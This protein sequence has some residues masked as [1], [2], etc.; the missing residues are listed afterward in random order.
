MKE[1]T[2]AKS[3]QTSVKYLMI[4]VLACTLLSCEKDKEKYVI[5]GIASFEA[6]INA[7]TVKLVE[8]AGGSETDNPVFWV[9]ERQTFAY[10]GISNYI[11]EVMR[12]NLGNCDLF[13]DI[14]KNTISVAFVSHFMDEI[15]DANWEITRQ[16]FE[17]VLSEGS[18]TYSPDF[19]TT[20]GVI[21]E[22]IDTEGTKWTSSQ[23]FLTE[24]TVSAMIND[25]DNKFVINYSAPQSDLYEED[26]VQYIDASFECNLYNKE[27]DMI[28]LK[29]GKLK[30]LY[31]ISAGSEYDK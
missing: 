23:I 4:L 28:T 20:E 7:E 10:S 8:T 6:V 29:N 30:S 3:K 24:D 15:Y 16:E 11:I 13:D 17:E 2:I 27:G 14:P 9:P 26:Y 1:I 22:W 21:I 5:E 25:D 31:L 19:G 12:T 18:K